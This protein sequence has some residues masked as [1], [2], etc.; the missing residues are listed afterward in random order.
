MS[1]QHIRNTIAL[2]LILTLANLG[3]SFAALYAAHIVRDAAK[4]TH[5]E[6]TVV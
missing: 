4:T 1:T 6:R 2:L 3:A 5:V